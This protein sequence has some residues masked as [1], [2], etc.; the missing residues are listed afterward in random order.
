MHTCW[1]TS[2]LPLE[3]LSAHGEQLDP[4]C[5][6]YFSL[7]M[8]QHS[9]LVVEGCALLSPIQEMLHVL[10]NTSVQMHDAATDAKSLSQPQRRFSQLEGLCS[11]SISCEYG[12]PYMCA[13]RRGCMHTC[14][15]LTST[16]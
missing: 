8:A 14:A 15:L 6:V 10:F 11:E 2:R 7:S 13:L 9:V 3:G 12:T 16:Y 1:G 5:N 4:T